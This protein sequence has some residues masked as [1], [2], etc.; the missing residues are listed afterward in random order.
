[1]KLM[2]V[3]LLLVAMYVSNADYGYTQEPFS[4]HSAEINAMDEIAKQSLFLCVRGSVSVNWR[5][6]L[7]TAFAKGGSDTL[8]VLK[9]SAFE[10]YQLQ[11]LARQFGIEEFRRYYSEDVEDLEGFIAGRYDRQRYI[12]LGKA[13]LSSLSD[14]MARQEKIKAVHALNFIKYRPLCDDI[15]SYIIAK[16]KV[17]ASDQH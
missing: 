8:W 1:M 5:D 7:S 16:S 4:L 12:D 15:S 3:I 10:S 11:E 9:V 2:K 13:N 17:V 14:Y 6:T